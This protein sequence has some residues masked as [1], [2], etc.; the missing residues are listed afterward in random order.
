M[1]ASKTALHGVYV[2][3]FRLFWTQ[4]LLAVRVQKHSP[5]AKDGLYAPCDELPRIACQRMPCLARYTPPRSNSHNT[6]LPGGRPASRVS[7]P[8]NYYRISASLP[9][10]IRWLPVTAPHFLSH[11]LVGVTCLVYSVSG[12]SHSAINLSMN[13]LKKAVT[14]PLFLK[15][16]PC[17]KAL[18]LQ[19]FNRPSQPRLSKRESLP[20]QLISYILICSCLAPPVALPQLTNT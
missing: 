17:S 20:V 6:S 12:A 1:D 19:N 2:P 14:V 16:A 18:F 5:V 13:A 8:D 9:Q 11:R 10:V 3:A 4:S 7:S 15:A